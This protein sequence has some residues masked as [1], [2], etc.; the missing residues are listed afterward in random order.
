MTSAIS[1]HNLSFAFENSADIFH[2]FSLKIDPGEWVSLIGQNGS[3]KSTLMRLIIG[4][5]NPR[6]GDV[7]VLG[8]I[9]VV[10]Q[11]PD[12]QFIGA[13]VEDELAFGL[14]NQQVDPA[15]MPAKI[16]KTLAQIDLSAYSTTSPDQLSGGQK[17]RVAIGSAL[18]L[19]ADILFLDEATSM[20][21]PLAKKSI[22][23]LIR[24]LHEDNPCLTI[25]NITHDPEEILQGQRVIALENG[26]IIADGRTDMIMS[27]TSFLHRHELGETF[28]AKLVA[29]LNRKRSSDK[30]IP[31]NI[32][33]QD[34]LISWLLDSNK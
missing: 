30:Q 3:G 21:D 11:N 31:K 14:E 17:Q 32:I 9:G 18:I 12:D 2:N 15:Q 26:K 6:I 16:K 23:T 4:L 1:I 13:T 20:L 28:A 7:E 19:N 8:K 10:F 22:I 24:Q 5:E 29:G 25:I 33:S 34:R 27:D